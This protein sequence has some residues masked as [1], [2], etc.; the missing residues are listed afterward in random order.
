MTRIVNVHEAKTRLSELMRLVE[1]GEEV[2]IARAGKPVLKLVAI[3]SEPPQRV[4]GWAKGLFPELEEL[5]RD[6]ERFELSEDDIDEW[7]KPFVDDEALVEL[8]KKQPE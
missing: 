4:L 6:P 8:L 1:A 7:Y 5:A 3:T 2:V